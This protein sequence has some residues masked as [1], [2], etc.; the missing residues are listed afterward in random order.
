MDILN[1][2][3]E[4]YAEVE[5]QSFDKLPVGT[6]N[7][8]VKKVTF[9]GDNT[10]KDGTK[11][12]QVSIQ[13][14]VTDGEFKG[15]SDFVNLNLGGRTPDTVR[16]SLSVFK[17]VM[18]KFGITA[19]SIANVLDDIEDIIGRDVEIKVEQQ[20]NSTEYTNTSITEVL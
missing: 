13:V 12:P 3:D 11:V 19:D 9:K 4:L 20:K 8:V 5:A 7:A 16:I 15:T 1:D 18:K 2:L 6:Y 10:W 17:G 14:S